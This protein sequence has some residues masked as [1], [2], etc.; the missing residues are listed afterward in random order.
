[1]PSAPLPVALEAPV[2]GLYAW[3]VRACDR[4]SQCS[5]WTAPRSLHVGR[6]A[7]DLDGDGY[8]DWSRVVA[9]ED[10]QRATAQFGFGAADAPLSDTALLEVS[11]AY[12]D[13]GHFDANGDGFA[14]VL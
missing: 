13:F 14:D 1:T 8:G 6:V 10:L 7:A 5:E 2:G 9:S 11:W 12:R 4:A 3:R